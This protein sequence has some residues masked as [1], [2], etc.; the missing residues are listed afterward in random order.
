LKKKSFFAKNTSASPLHAA[1]EQNFFAMQ[2]K[3][4]KISKLAMLKKLLIALKENI[5]DNTLFHQNVLLV[6][7]I[8]AEPSKEN[9]TRKT[10]ENALKSGWED[11]A[12]AKHTNLV[13][14]TLN[15]CKFKPNNASK[16]F[17]SAGETGIYAM[18]TINAQL[19]FAILTLDAS[20]FQ[21]PATTTTLAPRMSVMQKLD[22][23]TLLLPAMMQFP[24]QSTAA[25]LLMANAN[26]NLTILS[27]LPMTDV[28]L[29]SALNMVANSKKMLPA[30]EPLQP[31]TN[32]LLPLLAKLRNAKFKMMLL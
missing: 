12:N 21:R 5:V 31:A 13:T 25:M 19:T 7:L 32:A 28:Q 22:A 24:A 8:S 10:L 17:Q 20:T 29:L 2:K 18:I 4:A 3:I 26:T 16:D 23:P 15:A 9:V 1:R 6:S 14:L 11:I 27:A 30:R